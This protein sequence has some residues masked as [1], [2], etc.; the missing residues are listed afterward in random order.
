[1]AHRPPDDAPAPAGSPGARG[2]PGR[3]GAARPAT[4]L[5]ALALDPANPNKGTE[6]GRAALA[7]SL[8]RLGAGRSIVVDKH[9]VAIAGNKTI[10]AARAIGLEGTIVVPTRGDQLVVVQ[11]TDLDLEHDPVA[12]ELSIAD[13]RVAELGLEWDAAQL[14]AIV[15]EGA[16]LAAYF[17]DRELTQLLASVEVPGAGLTD[18][19]AIPAPPDEATTTPGDLYQLGPHRLLCGDAGSAADVDRLLAGATIDLVFADPPYDPPYNVKVEAR[20]NNAIA[21]GARGHTARFDAARNPRVKGSPTHAKLRPKDRRLLNDWM[22]DEEFATRLDAWFG[23][24]ARVLKPGRAFY[25]WGGFSNLAN[26]PRALAAARLFY[27]QVIIWHKAHPVLTR[28]DFMLDHELAFYGWRE[29]A[30][31]RFFGPPNVPDVWTVKKVP[32]QA[33]VHL[34]EKPVELGQRAFSYSSKPGERVLDLFG[35]SGSTLIVAQQLKRIAYLME[36]DP[37]YCDVI[38]QRWEAF[39][40]ERATRTSSTTKTQDGRQPTQRATARAHRAQAP[41]G[42]QGARAAR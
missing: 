20:S 21:A 34:T 19:D 27:S 8:K 39:T 7:E 28:K 9:G 6:R 2:R 41:A 25:L 42:R 13:N 31:H 32:A 24:L 29:G 36:L 10:E 30:G 33:M 3:D 5:A 23:Q 11:R 15:G 1:V 14:A 38:V 4:T 40:G 26:Y 18:P 35:G 17:S 16:D 37:L 12:R 22:S